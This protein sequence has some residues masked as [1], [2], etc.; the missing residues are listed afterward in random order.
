MPKVDKKTTSELKNITFSV[1]N[2]QFEKIN[3]RLDNWVTSK[4]GRV[5]SDLEAYWAILKIG[6][7]KAYEIFS[8][9]EAELILNVQNPGYVD[10]PSI[11]IW[12]QGGLTHNVFDGI[13]LNN[14]DEIWNVDGP[15]L[16]KKL[17]HL[18]VGVTAALLDWCREMWAKHINK[19]SWKKELKKF[20]GTNPG[21]GNKKEE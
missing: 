9:E 1:E 17:D 4:K 14:D 19:E 18:D 6:M 7:S 13:D 16:I 11:S 21:F 20:S 8:V 15:T 12:L 3:S 5:I 2:R 10:W